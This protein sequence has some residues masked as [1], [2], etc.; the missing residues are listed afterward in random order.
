VAAGAAALVAVTWTVWRN[1]GSRA[2]L[3]V[4]IATIAVALIDVGWAQI[5][6]SRV[7][8][9]VIANPPEAI[10]GDTVGFQLAFAGPRQFLTAA[11]PSFASPAVV[12]VD[13]PAAGLLA[14]AARAREVVT[15]IEVEVVNRG[16]AGFVACARRRTVPLARPLFVGPRPVP[17]AEPFPELFGAW[18]EGEPR[19]A[20][21]GDVV[22]SVRPYLPGD[23]M[24]RVH[25]PISARTGDLVVKEVEDTGTPRLVVALDLGAGGPAGERA[26]GRAAWYAV[27][28]LRRGYRVTLVTAEG[29]GANTVTDVATSPSDVT[30]RLAAAT[31]GTP[32]LPDPSARR[33]GGSDTR[34]LLVSDRGD[35]WR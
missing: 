3:F 31:R 11:V 7:R 20:P 21:A 32:T 2:S 1:S 8:V 17:G 18:G 35:S 5:A 25:W 23:P 14:G 22:R 19:P 27:E 34:L 15:V 12:G 24:R 10:V 16:L 29:G 30:R 26:A 28:G 9:T 13:V 6:T 33:P 4:C